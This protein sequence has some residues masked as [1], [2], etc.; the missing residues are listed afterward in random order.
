MNKLTEITEKEFFALFDKSTH[1]AL[2]RAA[3]ATKATHLVLFENIALDT[4]ASGQKSAVVVGPSCH[5]KTPADCVAGLLND[6]PLHRQCATKFC[7]VTSFTN[8]TLEKGNPNEK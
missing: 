5:F 4:V 6:L 2:R 8:P 1:T 3:T 7:K